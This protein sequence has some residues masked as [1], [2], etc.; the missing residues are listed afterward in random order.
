MIRDELVQL[1]DLA[2]TITD[3]AGLSMPAG[4]DA[5]SLMP[6]ATSAVAEPI[7][8]FQAVMLCNGIQNTKTCYDGYEEYLSYQKK[9]ADFEY[10]AEFNKEFHVPES[11]NSSTKMKTQKNW[12][13]IITKEYKLIEY[14]DGTASELYDLRNDPGEHHDLAEER[15]EVVETLRHLYDFTLPDSIME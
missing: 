10:I 5:K 7:R 2:A 14:L 8:D 15:P 1:H 12:A 4:T 11:T 3:F 13:S 9:M 6:L